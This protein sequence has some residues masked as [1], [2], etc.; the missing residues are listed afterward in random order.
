M[1]GQWQINGVHTEYAPEGYKLFVFRMNCST[2]S[3]K[4]A[5]INV[6]SQRVDN[7]LDTVATKKL[8]KEK[9]CVDINTYRIE[10]GIN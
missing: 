10:K 8:I 6:H 4:S 1:H 5:P 2:H 9:L 7:R 3:T